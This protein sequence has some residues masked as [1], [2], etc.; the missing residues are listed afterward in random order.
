[1]QMHNQTSQSLLVQVSN[2]EQRRTHACRFHLALAIVLVQR[3]I[4]ILVPK[5]STVS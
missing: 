5:Q 4:A 2:L 1:M 3:T